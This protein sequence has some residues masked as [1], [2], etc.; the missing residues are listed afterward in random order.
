[1]IHSVSIPTIYAENAD[2]TWLYPSN[3]NK[4][5]YPI[6]FNSN[7]SVQ[8]PQSDNLPNNHFSV[9]YHLKQHLLL[10]IIIVFLPFALIA[11]NV[12]YAG[13]CFN[14]SYSD[15]S[16]N[17]KY[18]N[19]LVQQKSDNQSILDKEFSK[20]FLAHTAFKNFDLV[21][22][23]A[24]A[25]KIALAIALNRE[26]IAFESIDGKTKAIYNLG[27]TIFIL[28][29]AEM[30]VIQSYPVKASFI[31]L[32]PQKPSDATI[33]NTFRRLYT[34]KITQ[35]I[36]E[37][38]SNIALRSANARSMKVANVTFSA[39]ALPYL[40]MYKDNLKAYSSLIAQHVTECFAYQMNITMLPYSKDYLGQKMSLAF[41]DAT[42]QNFS[43]PA[44]S[45]DIDVDVTKLIKKLYKE[46]AAEKVD[47][48]GTYVNVRIYDGELGTEY[49]KNEIKYGATKQ[50]SANQIIEDDFFNYNE[51]LLA[52]FSKQVT[53]TMKEDKKLMKGVIAKCVNY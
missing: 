23:Q 33:A 7:R 10:F 34:E 9:S 49:W 20:F 51:V 31:D 16:T 11:T 12:R 37:N 4:M 14:G 30:K 42:V 41:T 29:F 19:Q 21:F 46:T 32:Y 18:T 48:F 52:T 5:V 1:M 43:I 17:Y 13:F 24:E 28:D 15:I 25:E 44:A 6:D 22:G 53:T 38:M 39:D 36:A 27:C 40:S 8:T 3:N 50:T 26:D 47:I 45:Y 2:R 35:Q